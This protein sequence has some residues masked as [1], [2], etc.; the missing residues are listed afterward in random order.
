[1]WLRLGFTTPEDIDALQVLEAEIDAASPPL[2]NIRFTDKQVAT[3][4][5]KVADTESLSS[6]AGIDMEEATNRARALTAR[7]SVL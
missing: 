5:G 3:Y 6:M 7:V 1:M 2:N 4:I